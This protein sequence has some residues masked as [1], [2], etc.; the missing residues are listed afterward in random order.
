MA[1]NH[2]SSDTRTSGTLASAPKVVNP[3]R[4]LNNV[5]TLAAAAKRA[6]TVEPSAASFGLVSLVP[7]CCRPQVDRGARAGR[8]GCGSAGLCRLA[9]GVL[10]SI[11]GCD[12]DAL[13]DF[14]VTAFLEGG[15]EMV[16]VLALCIARSPLLFALFAHTFARACI[17]VVSAAQ[18][19]MHFSSFVDALRRGRRS[20]DVASGLRNVCAVASCVA[21]WSSVLQVI[22]GLAIARDHS[23]AAMMDSLSLQALLAP[24]VAALAS[25]GCIVISAGLLLLVRKSEEPEDGEQSESARRVT[26]SSVSRFLALRCAVLSES[27]GSADSARLARSR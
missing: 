13:N 7:A 22:W 17:G 11:F 23:Y 9:D 16:V 6:S 4:D 14:S 18:T 3:L 24:F 2:D 25:E 27:R 19:V 21:A 8:H 12:V 10:L 26:A 20:A 15:I 1:G 5:R